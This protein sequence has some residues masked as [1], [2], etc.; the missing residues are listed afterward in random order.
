MLF[1]GGI[2]VNEGPQ[3]LPHVPAEDCLVVELTHSITWTSARDTP[4]TL[5]RVEPRLE[6]RHY[7]VITKLWENSS[8]GIRFV[9]IHM[10]TGQALVYGSPGRIAPS[11]FDLLPAFGPTPIDNGST[12]TTPQTPVTTHPLVVSGL[13]NARASGIM[14]FQTMTGAG[15]PMDEGRQ[16]DT[17]MQGQTLV[18][19]PP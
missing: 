3:D 15:R 6:S 2:L 18:A 4:F 8:T 14:P 16:L 12:P 17:Y 9:G 1:I 19:S 13:A 5:P 7:P 11:I 10:L